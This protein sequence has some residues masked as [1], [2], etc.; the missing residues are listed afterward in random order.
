[1]EQKFSLEKNLSSSYVKDMMLVDKR[2][3][4][5]LY[6]TCLKP[7]LCDKAVHASV[8]SKRMS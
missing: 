4:G 2:Y 8:W 3:K 5:F 1:M 6:N 7:E